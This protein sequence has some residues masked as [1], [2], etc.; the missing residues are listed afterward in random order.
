ML[1]NNKIKLRAFELDDAEIV[2]QWRFDF[3]NYDYFYEFTPT[4][5]FANEFWVQATLK[6]QSEINFIVEN[7]ET[8]TSI[9]MISIIDID[10]RNHKCELGRVL[11]GD[12]KFRGQGIGSEMVNLLID[13]AFNHL[14][15]RKVYCEVFADNT[16]ALHLYK[17]SGFLVEGTLKSHIYKN[18]QY[19]DI[20]IFAKIR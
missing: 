3:D 5:K 14:N 17:K 1:N 13:Y 19:K 7:K 8:K 11:I 9:G 2:R 16:N 10:Y 18:G 6:K 15:M 12:K 4:S 20:V